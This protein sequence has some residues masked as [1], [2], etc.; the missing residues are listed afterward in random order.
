MNEWSDWNE[1]SLAVRQEFRTRNIDLNRVRNANDQKNVAAA[2]WTAKKK[3]QIQIQIQILYNI[4]IDIAYIYK[5]MLN[6]SHDGHRHILRFVVYG[7]MEMYFNFFEL[8]IY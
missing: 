3:I 6:I 4:C 8:F 5:L 7:L 2:Q 1:S